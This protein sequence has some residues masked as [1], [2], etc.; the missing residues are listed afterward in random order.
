[1]KT[2]FTPWRYAYLVGEKPTKGCIFCKALRSRKDETNLILH[3]GRT[4]FV[5]LNRYPYN[6][7]HLMVVP[8]AHLAELSQATP[9]QQREMMAL[10]TRCEKLLR[11]LYRCEGL[12]LGLNLGAAS[13]AG[14]HGHFH[15]HVVPRW[16]GDTNFMTVLN[17]TRVTPE[18]LETTYERLKPHFRRRTTRRTRVGKKG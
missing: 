7:G 4:N 16:S 14:V 12:N 11:K 9:A 8:N 15:L 17:S 3:R 18:A 10:A 13:G 6:S 2:L 5:I 1:M